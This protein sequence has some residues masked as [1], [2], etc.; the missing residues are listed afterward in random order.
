MSNASQETEKKPYGSK[1]Q[2]AEVEIGGHPVPIDAIVNMAFK[3]SG[4]VVGAWNSQRVDIREE[5]IAAAIQTLRDDAAAELTA[6]PAVPATARPVLA[7]VKAEAVGL[8][9][10]NNANA[11]T[12]RT[13]E[14]IVGRQPNGLPIIKS[15]PLASDKPTSMPLEHAMKFLIPGF[16]VTD[17]TGKVLTPI[18]TR[19]GG[20]AQIQLGDNEVIA[21]YSELS[22]SALFKRAKRL[23]DGD[24]ITA[25]ASDEELIEFIKD[26]TPRNEVGISRGSEGVHFDQAAADIYQGDSPLLLQVQAARKAA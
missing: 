25:N 18:P 2:P 24:R 4:L 10:D 13:H 22:H 8:V 14:I 7:S 17:D 19:D 12:T 23:P 15:Y 26:F 21:H 3:E 11:G 5:K 6:K 16:T 1:I 20:G 9:S